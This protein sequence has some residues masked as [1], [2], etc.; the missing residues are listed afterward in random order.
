MLL[1]IWKNVEELEASLNLAEIEAI[2]Q[3]SREKEH[4]HNKF[5]AAIQGIDLDSEGSE[6]AQEKFEK[7]K[8]R[9][10]A[11]LSGKSEESLELGGFG[12][13]IETE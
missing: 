11:K 4:R 7:A 5:M 10:E 13:D 12:I 1:G 9:V 2:V 3:A 6:S 8:R